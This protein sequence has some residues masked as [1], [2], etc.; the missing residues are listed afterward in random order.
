MVYFFSII[1]IIKFLFD[2]S[3]SHPIVEDIGVHYLIFKNNLLSFDANDASCLSNKPVIIFVHGFRSSPETWRFADIYNVLLN[4][5]DVNVI[6]VD[7][8]DVWSKKLSYKY[9][10]SQSHDLIDLL[11]NFINVLGPHGILKNLNDVTLVGH[12]LGAHVVGN[13][14]RK[15]N[16]EVKRIIALDPARPSFE[17]DSINERVNINSGKFVIVI[18]T[19]TKFFGLK[20]PLGHVDIYFNGGLLQPAFCSHSKAIEYLINSINNSSAYTAFKCD[21]LENCEQM[22][23]NNDEESIKMNMNIPVSTRGLYLVVTQN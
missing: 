23:I 8:S 22:I 3:E 15:L 18:H 21:T 4:K 2:Q 20:E 12:S 10:V 13:V 6:L 17:S 5:M 16:G 14:G 11:A 9:A 1:L 7:W 19:S